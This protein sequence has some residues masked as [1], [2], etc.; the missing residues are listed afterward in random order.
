MW[1]KTFTGFKSL[2]GFYK[3]I[4][5][6]YTTLEK[7]QENLKKKWIRYKWNSKREE[8]ISKAKKCNKKS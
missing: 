8:Y 1:P 5:D 3:N 4:K 7:A 2:L 6:G